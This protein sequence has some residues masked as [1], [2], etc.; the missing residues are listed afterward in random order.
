MGCH[1]PGGQC[2]NWTKAKL[3]GFVDGLVSRGVRTLDVWRADI[4]AEG[5]CTSSYY[6]ALAEYF[7]SVR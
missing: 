7:L 5:E 6:F 1:T 3:T 4:D 2:Y